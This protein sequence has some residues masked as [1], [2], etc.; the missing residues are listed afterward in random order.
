MAFAD[1]PLLCLPREL[2]DIIYKKL[3]TPPDP[4]KPTFGKGSGIDVSILRTCRCIHDEAIET[5]Y[6]II[7]KITMIS[8]TDRILFGRISTVSPPIS[9]LSRLHHLH[10]EVTFSSIN[11]GEC[12]VGIVN[13]V[14]WQDTLLPFG[15]ALLRSRAISTLEVSLLNTNQRKVGA[16]RIRSNEMLEEIRQLLLPFAYLP[17]EVRVVIGGFDTLEYFM[18]FESLREEHNGQ[19]IPIKDWMTRALYI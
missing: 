17:R 8:G 19:E 5:L 4:L 7:Y 9:A 10:L 11:R 18:M 12:E 16:K 2:R 6:S 3:L 1:S 14:R 13:A 15:L